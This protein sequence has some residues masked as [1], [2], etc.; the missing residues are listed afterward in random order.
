MIWS[1][2]TTALPTTSSMQ[3]KIYRSFLLLILLVSRMIIHHAWWIDLSIPPRSMS[4]LDQIGGFCSS[5]TNNLLPT[6]RSTCV[7]RVVVGC[8]ATPTSMTIFKLAESVLA[9]MIMDYFRNYW[10]PRAK[11]FITL[12]RRKQIKSSYLFR[13]ARDHRSKEVIFPLPLESERIPRGGRIISW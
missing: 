6:W 4:E 5:E 13:M 9:K 10:Y 1:I 3:A 7:G 11:R 2:A 8:F 12:I